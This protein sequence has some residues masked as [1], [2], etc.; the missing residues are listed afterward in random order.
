MKNTP[1]RQGYRNATTGKPFKEGGA[2]KKTSK[3]KESK[4]PKK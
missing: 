4:S 3:S 2:A 1:E